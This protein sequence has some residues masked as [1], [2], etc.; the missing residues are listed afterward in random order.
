MC[1]S[2]AQRGLPHTDLLVGTEVIDWLLGLDE[3]KVLIDR[4][5]GIFISDGIRAQLSAYDGVTFYGQVN[6]AGYVLNLICVDEQYKNSSGVTTNYFPADSVAVT[7]PGAGHLMYAQVTQIVN[8]QFQ[9]IADKRVPRL[10]IDE[11][12][13]TRELWL[14]ARPFAAPKNYS[15]WVVANN[16]VT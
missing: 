4:N 7:A 3:F 10:F 9:T 15:P 6:I 1:R 12:H 2:L 5:S 8:G 13:D 11:R 16:I 14:R